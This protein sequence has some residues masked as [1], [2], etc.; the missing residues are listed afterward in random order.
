MASARKLAANQANAKKSTGPKTKRGK[1][2][3][4]S[5]ANKHGLNTPVRHDPRLRPEVERLSRL[6]A[7]GRCDEECLFYAQEIADAR[8]EYQRACMAIQ[9]VTDQHFGD[10]QMS[11]DA[12]HGR[13]GAS[14]VGR[15]KADPVDPT[16]VLVSRL[17]AAF[18]ERPVKSLS[19]VCQLS[20]L[21]RYACRALSRRK[22][23]VRRFD[24][25]C[26]RYAKEQAAA[27]V[28][29]AEIPRG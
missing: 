21:D 25:A 15:G 2:R 20:R 11:S 17:V 10:V 16:A 23:A 8:I 4:S 1:I 7:A 6:I 22:S 28:T 24:A 5:N 18:T 3:A 13:D 14:P 29:S 9:Q 27:S 19:I 12:G 26:A